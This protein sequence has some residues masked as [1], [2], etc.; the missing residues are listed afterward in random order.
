VP[1][2]SRKRLLSPDFAAHLERLNRA[3]AFQRARSGNS[4]SAREAIAALR[5][6]RAVLES[7]RSDR[8]VELPI[9]T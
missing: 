7:A 6:A 9:E 1:A 8:A 3:F 5:V 2:R 4:S